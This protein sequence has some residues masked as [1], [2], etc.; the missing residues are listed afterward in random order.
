MIDIIGNSLT[1]PGF[2]LNFRKNGLFF[3]FL[4]L[5]TFSM[6]PVTVK[7]SK[8]VKNATTQ[9]ILAHTVSRFDLFISSTCNGLIGDETAI[10]TASQYGFYKY[11][12]SS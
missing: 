6:S 3:R 7:S 12:H 10:L 11:W 4:R 5:S 8:T 9:K 2:P 1:T